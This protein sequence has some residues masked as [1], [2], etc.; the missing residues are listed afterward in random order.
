VQAVLK[1]AFE[2]ANKDILEYLTRWHAPELFHMVGGDSDAQSP[3]PLVEDGVGPLTVFAV[4]KLVQAMA[5]GSVSTTPYPPSLLWLLDR[6]LRPDSTERLTLDEFG[7]LLGDMRATSVGSDRGVASDD[8]G[9]GAGA[10]APTPQAAAEFVDEAVLLALRDDLG[11]AQ[12][13]LRVAQSELRTKTAIAEA[14]SQAAARERQVRASG[15][16]F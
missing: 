5:G 13:A 1:L 10:P 4:A 16:S 7:M 15:C 6:A 3:E 11:R 12:E 2:P 9:V 8:V 14:Q